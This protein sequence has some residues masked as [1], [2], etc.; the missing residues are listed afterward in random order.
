MG[1][2]REKPYVPNPSA[3]KVYDE[4]Y[5]EYARLYDYF[6]RGENNVMKVLKRI[7]SAVAQEEV[8]TC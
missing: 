2:V 3:V 6:G 7:K 1:S 5:R 8:K 4:L